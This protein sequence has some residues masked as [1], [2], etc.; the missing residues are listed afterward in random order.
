MWSE[1]SSS[2]KRKDEEDTK[3]PPINPA[4]KREIEEIFQLFDTDGSG[5]MELPELSVVFWALGFL[6]EPG[7]T[8]RRVSDYFGIPEEELNDFSLTMNHFT[9]FMAEQ[10]R[11]RENTE[12][13]R[14]TFSLFDHEKKG[15]IT[16]RDIKRVCREINEQVSEQELEMMMSHIDKSG[17]G[18]VTLD[19][20]ITVMAD[21]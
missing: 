1:A 8:E 4:Q 5:T 13:L 15:Y 17:D 3:R 6:L 11:T 14:L 2:E 21:K 16:M 18:S 10:I 12:M 19:E 20:W 7:D 9:E